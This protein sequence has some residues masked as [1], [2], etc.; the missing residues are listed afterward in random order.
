MLAFLI[1][2]S[3]EDSAYQSA[4]EDP[5]SQLFER[6]QMLKPTLSVSSEYTVPLEIMTYFLS[7]S[8]TGTL[9]YKKPKL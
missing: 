6:K 1:V 5:C 3:M 7:L 2:T 4:I 8:L 9:N